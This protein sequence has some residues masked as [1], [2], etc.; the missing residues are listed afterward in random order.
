VPCIVA[1][2]ANVAN[3]GIHVKDK[4]IGV[5]LDH[6]TTFID[7]CHFFNEDGTLP[8]SIHPSNYSLL[9]CIASDVPP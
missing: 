7:L 4:P 2:V 6:E 1:F 9:N 3:H 8:I 5:A